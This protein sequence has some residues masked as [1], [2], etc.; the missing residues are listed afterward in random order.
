M[1]K[2][3][4][5]FV[6]ICLI[7]VSQAFGAGVSQVTNG[8]YVVVAAW[9]EDGAVTNEPIPFEDKIIFKLF[10][11]KTNRLEAFN[12]PRDPAFGLKIKMLDAHGKEVLKTELG[13]KF[14]SRWNQLYGFGDTHLQTAFAY[15]SYKD[16]PG[17]GGAQILPP[18]SKLFQMQIPGIYTLEMQMQ[19]FRHTGSNDLEEQHRNLICFSPVKIQ[20][21]KPNGDGTLHATKAL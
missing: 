1:I 15:G 13:K 9:G 14:G 8:V 5:L 4:R 16:D 3:N 2:C 10:N 6:F 21:E 17:L 11:D 18:A 19:I 20:V 12:Y 7:C